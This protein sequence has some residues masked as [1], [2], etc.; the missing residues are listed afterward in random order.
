M[1]NTNVNTKSDKQVIVDAPNIEA[2]LVVKNHEKIG[3][4]TG[5]RLSDNINDSCKRKTVTYYQRAV[6]HL[7]DEI[8]IWV[9]RSINGGA[10]F[11]I[12]KENVE[13]EYSSETP[14]EDRNDIETYKECYA[15]AKMY[16]SGWEN[17]NDK[18]LECQE[19]CITS[20][21]DIRSN[22]E[23]V[24]NQLNRLNSPVDDHIKIIFN[25]INN[26]LDKYE[27]CHATFEKTKLQLNRIRMGRTPAYNKQQQK[28]SEFVKG[29]P[30]V[31][32][33]LMKRCWNINPEERPTANEAYQEILEYEESGTMKL[34][35]VVDANLGENVNIEVEDR[36]EIMG[37]YSEENVH[38]IVT[39]YKASQLKT[40]KLEMSDDIENTNSE[41]QISSN[42]TTLLSNNNI[43]IKIT[44]SEDPISSNC[45]E[46]KIWK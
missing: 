33:A 13:Y 23:I 22:M 45:D 12:A 26:K 6:L 40:E 14:R 5:E 9:D 3:K 34:K 36:F 44:I 31:Y 20:I 17:C 35:N 1:T 18:L 42:A 25:D 46:S 30:P 21:K 16:I 19:T 10:Q 28:C 37:D 41:E 4:A 32:E 8:K 24:Y 39:K 38:P 11:K 43:D 15:V 7:H 29:T 27:E 2:I